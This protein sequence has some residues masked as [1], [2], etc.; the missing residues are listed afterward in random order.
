MLTGYV[1]GA[2]VV[3]VDWLQRLGRWSLGRCF[4]SVL[5]ICGDTYGLR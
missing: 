4:G 3:L 5:F 2:I 1:H